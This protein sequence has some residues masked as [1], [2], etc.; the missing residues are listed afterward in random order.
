MSAITV[1]ADTE[2]R[3]FKLPLPTPT[4]S[5]HPSTPI[6]DFTHILNV[7]HHDPELWIRTQLQGTFQKWTARIS[8]PGS[9]R[10]EYNSSS[11]LLLIG[12]DTY[13]V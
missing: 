6:L 10:L 5:I 11:R 13:K 8:W 2:I 9:V 3:N 1:L 4:R 12:I 7:S